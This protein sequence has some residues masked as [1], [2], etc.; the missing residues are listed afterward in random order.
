MSL[1]QLELAFNGHDK[2]LSK[3]VSRPSI[4]ATQISPIEEWLHPFTF[5]VGAG[6]LLY[7]VHIERETDTRTQHNSQLKSCY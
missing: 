2:L 3:D 5:N 6:G 7:F 4:A 1:S